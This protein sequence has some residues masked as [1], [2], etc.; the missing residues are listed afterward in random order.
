MSRIK[1]NPVQVKIYT[2]DFVLS[3]AI[4]TKPGGY[5]ERV[6]D[7]V[8]DCSGRFLVLTDVTFR[9]ARDESA[10]P[11]KCR[12]LMVRLENINILVPFD[13]T[14]L[15]GAPAAGPAAPLPA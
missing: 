3:G 1:T 14:E 4:H 12:T 10:V 2:D 5:K 7:I 11:K 13:E 15:E 8:N 6:S 9:S